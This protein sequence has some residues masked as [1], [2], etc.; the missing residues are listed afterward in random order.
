VGGSP[1]GSVEASPARPRRDPAQQRTPP[2]ISRW[3]DSPWPRCRARPI[4]TAATGRA[5]VAANDRQPSP[6]LPPPCDA[7]RSKLDPDAALNSCTYS[8]Y[9]HPICIAVSS[10]GGCHEPQHHRRVEVGQ[11]VTCSV[12]Y[13]EH[14]R[15]PHATRVC[16]PH[17]PPVTACT[18][19]S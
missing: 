13:S 16:T 15:R 9:T 19:L 11:G 8:Y 17:K 4:G 1:R 5:H 10:R 18:E 12:A 2:R 7:P 14:G 6:C 3:Y